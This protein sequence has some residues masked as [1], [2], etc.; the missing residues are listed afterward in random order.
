MKKL[1]SEVKSSPSYSA[2]I[3]DFLR[4]DNVHSVHRR[5]IKRTF[6]RRRIITHYPFQIFQADLIEY[7]SSS[8]SYANKGYRFILVVIDSFS[9]MLYAEPIKRKSADYMADAIDKIFE[10][11]DFF[12]N[13]LIT[14]RGLEFYNSKVQAVLKKYGIN[15]YSLKTKTPWKTP[16][17]ER[18]IRTLKSRFEKYFHDK[19]TKT[20]IDVLNQFV[21]NYNDTPH[22]SIGM[23]PSKVT[24]QNSKQVY[25]RMFGDV[26]LRVVPRLA[27]GDRVRVLLEK[28]LFDKGYTQNW[29]DKI[30][31]I[32]T[33]I[34]KAGVVWYK[35]SELDGTP[36]ERIRYYYQLNLVSKNADKN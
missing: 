27:V 2:K 10:Q 7:S 33:V 25:K 6:P 13:S 32:K 26:D 18:V 9:K 29:S 15:H 28:K 22:R 31:L 3:A 16:M 19:K 30:Y 1:Y 24:F 5:I 4:K 36:V 11:F 20:W 34:Q 35:L 21:A 12:P 8:F 17:A 14:D 23:A